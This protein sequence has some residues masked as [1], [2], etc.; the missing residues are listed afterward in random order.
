MGKIISFLKK[1]N[2]YKHLAGGFLV[3][4]LAC[5]AYPAVYAAVI[6]GSCLEFKDW[7]HGCPWDWVDWLCTFLG[8]ILAAVAW[9]VIQHI[10]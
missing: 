7:L 3:G 9:A 4:I 6:A 5:G 8:G 2:R 10:Q 1:S